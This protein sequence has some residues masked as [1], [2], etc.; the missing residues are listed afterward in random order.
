MVTPWVEV[1]GD[2]P[3]IRVERREGSWWPMGKGD[4]VAGKQSKDNSQTAIQAMMS[5]SQKYGR[6]QTMTARL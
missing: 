4:N 3:G 5:L 2:P 1:A 6:A